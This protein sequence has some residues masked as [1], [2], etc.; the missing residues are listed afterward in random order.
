M[1]TWRRR[2]REE[3]ATR[4]GSHRCVSA[5]LLYSPISAL[6]LVRLDQVHHRIDQGEM[7]ER[8]R[9]VAEVVSGVRVDL[10]SVEME[11]AGKRQ[12]LAAQGPGPRHFSDFDQRRNQPKRAYG[13]G[14]LLP[15]ETVIGLL[16]AVAQ[17]EFVFG[18]L[19]GDG[20]DGRPHTRIVRRAETPT[21]A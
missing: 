9:E 13:E 18:Q 16:D 1:G 15:A 14:A 5:P 3:R 19:V 12:Q 20:E 11:F 21:A 4:D 6:M 7:R 17:D 10:L 8:L 2:L